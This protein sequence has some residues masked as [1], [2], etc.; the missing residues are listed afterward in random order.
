MTERQSSSVGRRA[1][2]GRATPRAAERSARLALATVLALALAPL[3][4]CEQLASLIDSI[5]DG[6]ECTSNAQCLG[7][8]CISDFPGGYCSTDECDTEGCSNIFGSEC[9]QLPNASAPLCYEHCDDQA[10]CRDGYSCFAIETVRVCLPASFDDQLAS[11]G[12]LG[13]ACSNGAQCE[14][15]SCLTNMV[16]GYCSV[17]DCQSDAACGSGR[18]LLLTDEEA[19]TEL[20]ACFKGCT[21]DAACRFGYRCS[22]PDGG[23]GVCVP[24]D[25]GA[26]DP[27]RNPNG[28]PDGQPCTVDIN[29]RG[30]TCLRAAEGY[31]GGYCTTLDCAT[32]GCNDP[33]GGT[34]QC[35]VITQ[36]TACFVDCAADGQC[37]EGYKCVGADTGAGYC[38]PPVSAPPPVTPGGGDIAVQCDSGGGATR[39]IRFD[40]A[41]DT[42]AFTVVPYSETSNVRPLRLRLPNGTVGADF[43]GTYKFLDVNPFYIETAAPVFFP[44]APQFG[45]IA[46]QGGGTYEL[47]V[48]VG[49]GPLCWYVLQKSTPGTRIA[50]NITFVGVTG[51]NASNAGNHAGFNTMIDTFERIYRSAGIELDTLRLFDASPQYAERYAVIRD[52]NDLFRIVEAAADP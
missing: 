51:L 38:A 8:V 47:D 14:S 36:E 23:G 22:D 16:G 50:V 5:S 26:T 4:G 3:A 39:T 18:C 32:V 46:Q 9:L 43:D 12:S 42:L 1:T 37:R 21:D 30:G 35:R 44:A 7:G 13:S 34:A 27:V 25:D 17:L 15:G 52:L 10:G 29:C 48:A 6:A 19:G 31:P 40:I 28:A 33:S 2:P 49:S 24:R 20:A 11:A 41:A 45:N